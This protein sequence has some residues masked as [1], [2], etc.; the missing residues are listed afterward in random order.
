MSGMGCRP[1]LVAVLH[2]TP[3]YVWIVKNQLSAQDHSP[4]Q[5]FSRHVTWAE[6]QTVSAHHVP[7]YSCLCWW[8]FSL[9]VFLAFD[10][11]VV[12]YWLWMCYDRGESRLAFEFCST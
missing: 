9:V 8:T 12:Q 5:V 2:L 7:I 10:L 3:F 4:N 6:S 11:I 1:K